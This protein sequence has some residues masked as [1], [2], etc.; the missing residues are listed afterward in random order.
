[1]VRLK[2]YSM[3][4][5]HSIIL[6]WCLLIVRY[7]FIP[8]TA[9]AQESELIMQFAPGTSPYDLQKKI[10]QRKDSEKSAF[11]KMK[12]TLE[13]MRLHLLHQLTPEEKLARLK[14]IDTQA[15]VIMKERVFSDISTQ[16]L[17]LVRLNGNWSIEQA[18]IL[19]SSIPEIV[20]AEENILKFET[21]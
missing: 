16:E 7:W 14:Q 13:D 11:G 19:Y 17:Y 20:F 18:E 8:D 6:L 10:I 9:H 3:R 2:V 15:G 4:T 5:A 12:V 21:L 1:M